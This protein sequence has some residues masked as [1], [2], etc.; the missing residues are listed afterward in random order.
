MDKYFE[1]KKRENLVFTLHNI[2]PDWPYLSMQPTSILYAR[3]IEEPDGPSYWSHLSGRYRSYEEQQEFLAN[4]C[5]DKK[6]PKVAAT[7]T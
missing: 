7:Y 3:P 4:G 6:L 5:I 1:Q 2:N